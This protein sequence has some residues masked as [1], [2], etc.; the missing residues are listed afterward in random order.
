T[1]TLLFTVDFG[2]SRPLRVDAVNLDGAGRRVVLDNASAPHY[3]AS[4]QL[5]FQRDGVLLVAPFDAATLAVTGPAAPLLDDVRQDGPN[6]DGATPQLVVSRAGTLAYVP[7]VN[8]MRVMGKVSRTGVFEALDLPPDRINRV[9]VAPGGQAVAFD[10][11]TGAAS[12]NFANAS[13]V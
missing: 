7:A 10:V 2:G 3:V 12:T 8:P 9:A 5:V 1:E 6:A 13:E 11:T 4:G